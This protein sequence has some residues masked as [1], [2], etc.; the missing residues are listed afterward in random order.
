[1]SMNVCPV[2]IFLTTKSLVCQ[3]GSVMHPR[4]PGC[5]AK[6]LLCLPEGQ[7]HSEGLYN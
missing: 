3:L 5:P 6:R 1:M 2:D 7:G 4:E